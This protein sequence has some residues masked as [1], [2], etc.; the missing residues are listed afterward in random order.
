MTNKPGRPPKK[1]YIPE[2]TPT[3][4]PPEPELLPEVSEVSPT[5]SVPAD[6]SETTYIEQPPSIG[7]R[8]NWLGFSSKKPYLFAKIIL[9]SKTIILKKIWIKN[10]LYFK[11]SKRAYNISNKEIY[12]EQIKGKWRP[13]SYYFWEYP[14][15]IHFKAVLEQD[16]ILTITGD[17]YKEVLDSKILSE[18]ARP[19][20]AILDALI[21]VC[22]IVTTIGVL[23]LLAKDFGLIGKATG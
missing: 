10:E 14:S 13:V 19:T 5:H 20:S 22:V 8:R 2:L 12:T 6:I 18:L 1:P 17:T 4:P 23:T 3:I 21:L 16:T 9:P 11:H 7:P 15:P